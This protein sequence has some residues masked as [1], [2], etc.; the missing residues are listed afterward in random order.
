MF[1]ILPGFVLQFMDYIDLQGNASFDLFHSVRMVLRV[2]YFS[3]LT[4]FFQCDLRNVTN[5]STCSFP[6]K[7]ILTQAH[8]NPAPQVPGIPKVAAEDATLV[9]SNIHGEKKAIPILKGTEILLDVAGIHFNR[10]YSWSLAD[11]CFIYCD[12]IFF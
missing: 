6:P 3:A 8:G 7:Y 10:T 5:V 12:E 1:L 2:F 11:I 9:A 4:D